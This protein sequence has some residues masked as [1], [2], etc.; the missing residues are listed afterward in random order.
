[1][2]GGYLTDDE[3]SFVT[4]VVPTLCVDVLPRFTDREGQ[5]FLLIKRLDYADRPGWCTVGG[6]VR[7]DEPIADA[8]ARHIR[9]TLGPDVRW[10]DPDWARPDLVIDFKREADLATPHDPRKHSISLEWVV[11]F[12]GRPI[13]SDE[14]EEIA[15]F[16]LESLPAAHEFAFGLGE[17][18]PRMAAGAVTGR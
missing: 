11:D 8:A 2:A 12:E 7:F 4:S 13:A 16:P 18:L 1:M 10:T 3:Y 9:A 17:V 15:M 5:P 6:R 14:A